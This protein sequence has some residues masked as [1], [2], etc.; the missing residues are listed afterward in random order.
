MASLS[1]NTVILRLNTQASFGK[2]KTPKCKSELGIFRI[3]SVSD[4]VWH[5]V[6]LTFH[7][8]LLNNTQPECIYIFIDGSISRFVFL[9]VRKG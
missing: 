3:F 1:I 2:E 7:K 8:N 5:C 6:L 9:N 4:V